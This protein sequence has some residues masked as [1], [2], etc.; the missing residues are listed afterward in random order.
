MQL[1][2]SAEVNKFGGCSGLLSL[3]ING[4]CWNTVMI[5]S[6]EVYVLFFLLFCVNLVEFDAKLLLDT[7][8]IGMWLTESMILG[9]I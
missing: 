4:V 2:L 3:F 6:I 1:Y 7:S 5:A 9:Y 8:C